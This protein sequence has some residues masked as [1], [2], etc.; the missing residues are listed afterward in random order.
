M[1]VGRLDILLVTKTA[2]MEKGLKKGGTLAEQFSKSLTRTTRQLLGFGT[3]AA[4]VWMVVRAFQAAVRTADEFNDAMA[5]STAIMGGLPGLDFVTKVQMALVAHQEA[6]GTAFTPKE[7]A[8]GFYYLASAGMDAKQS[9]VLL[10][11][12]IEFAQAANMD[13]A[14]GIELVTDA[15]SALGLH[16]EDT[17]QNMESFVRVS[18]ALTAANTLADA[19]VE[20]F[21]ESLTRK[22]AAALRFL[23]KDVEE[24]VGIL[25]AL[26]DQGVKG[27]EAGTA[28][29]I[30]MRELTIKAVENTAAFRKH[31]I[32]VYE[33][34]GAMRET[35][36]IF[37][38]LERELA[39]YTTR[40]KIAVLAELGFQ[41]KSQSFIKILLD[42][43]EAMR[44]NTRRIDEM[45]GMTK[46]V[47]GNS[48]TQWATLKSSFGTTFSFIKTVLIGMPLEAWAGNVNLQIKLLTGTL[49]LL[50]Q[51]LVYVLNRFEPLR[52][53]A[54]W[55]ALWRGIDVG[56]DDAAITQVD[57]L[58][59]A[60][61]GLGEQLLDLDPAAD[62]AE[63]SLTSLLD[64]LEHR[65][66]TFGMTDLEE[67]V[68]K[69]D[70]LTAGSFDSAGYNEK[71]ERGMGLITKLEGL[72]TGGEIT[73]KF[74]AMLAELQQQVRTFGLDDIQ[75]AR[76]ELLELAIQGLDPTRWAVARDAINE[77]QGKQFAATL[78]TGWETEA[79][80]GRRM[81]I[82]RMA[83]LEGFA[84]RFET[85][86]ERFGRMTEDLAG[87]I[88]DG[89][90]LETAGRALV[91]GIQDR[92]AA[93]KRDIE[94]PRGP[95]AVTQGTQQAF[96]LEMQRRTRDVAEKQLTAQEEAND[97]L[98]GIRDGLEDA[99]LTEAPIGT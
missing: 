89:L 24:T 64:R 27:A 71:W 34:S 97:I 68:A 40:K 85:P 70:A 63:K 53:I 86:E 15:Q 49:H 67:Q 28:L 29:N 30:V 54:E 23:G 47:A 78:K 48:I 2:Q 87:K 20:Q 6:F 21:A 43:S 73:A 16:T 81:R 50:D 32:A 88:A 26:A 76:Q 77:L 12:A 14:R 60:V 25:A 93:L 7:A 84:R 38:D 92:D 36:D 11:P 91:A 37:G 33:D 44:E 79:R 58:T 22:A 3:A 59:D 90:D 10:R 80:E 57:D 62:A 9:M 56:I 1:L 75:Q 74:D 66:S 55:I 51:A 94:Q 18:D 5:K 98:G 65:V 52:G 39:K 45:G 17:R 42:S 31:K 41:A 72:Q 61:D 19:S 82:S 83:E 8:K 46:R 35:A 95:A 4:G 99:G 13:L 96:A 69:L